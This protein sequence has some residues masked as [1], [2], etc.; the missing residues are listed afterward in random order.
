MLINSNRLFY[1]G[2]LLDPTLFEPIERNHDAGI[3]KEYF[4]ITLV[5]TTKGKYWLL[6]PPRKEIKME[7]K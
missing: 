5:I 4:G 1:L 2:T 6:G 3:I 7:A